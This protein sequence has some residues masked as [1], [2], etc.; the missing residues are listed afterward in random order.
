MLLSEA[1][2]AFMKY[3]HLKNN[4]PATLE[5][6][7]V[8][9]NSFISWLG[10][11]DC[12]DLTAEH[13]N[14]YNLY[15]RGVVS[16]VSVRTY[17]RHIRV[18]VNFCIR[19]KW[20]SAVY[21]DIIIPKNPVKVVEVLTPA[22][23]SALM[24]V[25]DN[26]FYGLR[27]KAMVMLMLDC[28]LRASEVV[29]LVPDNINYAYKYIKVHGKGRKER[30][31]P[32][33]SALMSTLRKYFKLRPI[34][35]EFVFC[36]ALGAPLKRNAFKKMFHTLRIKTGIKRLHPHLLRHTFA[37]NYLLYGHGDV[38]KLSMLLGHSSITTTQIYLHYANYYSFMQQ[39]DSYSFLDDIGTSG[40]LDFQSNDLDNIF[41]DYEF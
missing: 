29:T 1:F 13:V 36:S 12:S 26:G 41:D 21:E 6:Y 25:F 7:T 40:A 38:Y 30:I 11:F 16:L 27:N 31:V 14:D 15:L 23:I 10:D 33:G 4:T 19:K 17:I 18:F 34:F 32:M 22:E 9:L 20:C 35:A 3:Q 8:M 24:S 5:D 39:H 37:T 2:T 28:G